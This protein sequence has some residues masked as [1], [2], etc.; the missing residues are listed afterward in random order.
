MN[1]E[2]KRT[3]QR[4]GQVAPDDSPLTSRPTAP[5]PAPARAPRQD[6]EHESWPARAAQYFAEVRGELSKVLWPR[7]PEVVNY[8]TVVLTTLVLLAL[9]IFGLNYIFA[10]GVIFQFK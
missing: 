9:L 5:P 1:R 6:A 7:R 10:K 2:T 3:L 4:Q 8:S